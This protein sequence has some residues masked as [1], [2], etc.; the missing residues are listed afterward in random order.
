[1]VVA[2]MQR[3]EW[4]ETKAKRNLRKHGIDFED[5]ITVFRD[6]HAMIEL[7]RYVDG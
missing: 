6:E 5:A 1:M 7:E 4:D 3:F 2:S